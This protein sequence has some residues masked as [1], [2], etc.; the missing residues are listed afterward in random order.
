MPVIVFGFS[1]MRRG[2]SFRS[3]KRVPTHMV[4]ALG[5]AH[6]VSTVVQTLG[7][8]TF[9]GKSV[10]NENG[11]KNVTVLTTNSD[12][13]LCIGYQKYVEH[14]AKRLK[15]GDTFK[16][17]VTGANEKIP[18]YANFLQHCNSRELGRIKGVLLFSPLTSSAKKNTRYS[19]SVCKLSTGAR[20]WFVNTVNM[21]TLSPN[22]SEAKEM[23]WFNGDAQ[24]L[25]R[26]LIRLGKRHPS[27]AHE[28]IMDDLHE[29]EHQS[30]ENIKTLLD[31][32]CDEALI[33]KCKQGRPNWVDVLL[34]DK[35]TSFLNPEMGD[36]PDEDECSESSDSESSDESL[37][38]GS[39]VDYPIILLDSDDDDSSDGDIYEMVESD[40]TITTQ[41][42]K[43]RRIHRQGCNANQINRASI[44]D[45]SPRK[46]PRKSPQT[47]FYHSQFNGTASDGQSDVTISS[48]KEQTRMISPPRAS[49]D[50]EDFIEQPEK[51]EQIQY[52]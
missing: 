22:E 2:V 44:I 18:G 24:K 7:R 26:S 19:L 52:V 32:F 50:R 17:A 36:V 51:K 20:Q 10:L 43:K 14:V 38:P 28:D 13:E 29:V 23:Y 11:F 25:L 1:K 42:Q 46:S 5:R 35:L 47:I 34:L 16:A 45:R 12:L 48:Y 30:M 6:N 21:C 37:L 4:M 8:A 49:S 41:P 15:Q 40:Q 31:Q 39:A 9:N 27:V 3:S 33:S